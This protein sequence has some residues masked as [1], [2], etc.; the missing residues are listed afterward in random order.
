MS[1]E[2]RYCHLNLNVAYWDYII[3]ITCGLTAISMLPFAYMYIKAYING[4][5]KASKFLFMISSIFL[6]VVFSLLIL[7]GAAF[8]SYCHDMELNN[9]L[10]AISVQLHSLH[11]LLL[12]GILFH[13]LDFIFKDTTMAISIY[14]LIFFW[15]YYILTVITLIIGSI[16]FGSYYFH[17]LT[18][19]MMA[20][21]GILVVTLT[22]ILVCLFINKLYITHKLSAQNGDILKQAIT[23]TALL[24]FVST[25]NTMIAYALIAIWNS[26]DNIHYSFVRDIFIVGDVYTNLFVYCYHINILINITINCVGNAIQRAIKYGANVLSMKIWKS[27]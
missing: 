21:C 2:G 5:L 20:I 27:L 16:L 13:R 15:A 18:S 14:T 7:L 6:I 1:E 17:S 9:T 26:I 23:K 22:V 3:P 8:A 12:V 25:C 10:R 11:T 4:Q 24:T 19:I